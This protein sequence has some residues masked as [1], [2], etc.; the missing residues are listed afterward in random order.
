MRSKEHICE[1]CQT[2]YS[3]KGPRKSAKCPNCGETPSCDGIRYNYKSKKR[4]GFNF[5]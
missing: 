4:D 2:T 3:F 1:F 5:D